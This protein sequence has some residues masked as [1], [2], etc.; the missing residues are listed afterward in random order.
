M[1]F[2]WTQVRKFMH[3]TRAKRTFDWPVCVRRDRRIPSA[4]GRNNKKLEKQ[5]SNESERKSL[6]QCLLDLFR[7]CGPGSTKKR[8][9]NCWLLHGLLQQ[10]PVKSE[11]R[12]SEASA[13]AA[14]SSYR[15]QRLGLESLLFRCKPNA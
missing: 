13:A 9:F 12:P 5:N 10:I 15:T 7:K 8:I 14:S 1:V 3:I 11:S 6:L 4:T 2:Y